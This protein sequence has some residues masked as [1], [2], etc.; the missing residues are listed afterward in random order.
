M[1]PVVAVTLTEDYIRGIDPLRCAYE[2]SLKHLPEEFGEDDILQLFQGLIKKSLLSAHENYIHP[3]WSNTIFIKLFNGVYR[4][5]MINICK[6][7]SR[8]LKMVLAG[9]VS[10]GLAA[11]INEFEKR[12]KKNGRK[13]EK[14]LN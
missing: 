5:L 4:H 1:P 11:L 2:N 14:N 8:F 9:N 6:Q 7:N 12:C 3:D 13:F 10:F